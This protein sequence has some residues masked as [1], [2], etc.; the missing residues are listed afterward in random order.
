MRLVN[1]RLLPLVLPLGLIFAL[2]ACGV[3]GG[4]DSHPQRAAAPVQQGPAADYPVVLG[5]PYTIDGTLYSPVDTLNY[6][7]VGLAALDSEGG[8]AISAALRTLPVPSYVE[9]TSLETGRTILVRAERRGPMSGSRFVALSPGAM[10]QLG[11]SDGT[12]VRVRRVNPPEQERAM[13]RRGEQVPARMDTP[14]SLVNVLKRKLPAGTLVSAPLAATPTPTVPAAMPAVPKPLAAA[15]IPPSKHP[16]ATL[17]SAPTPPPAQAA[18]DAVAPAP[19]VPARGGFIVQAGAFARKENADRAAAELS[20]KVD[21]AG[22]LYR[23]RTGPFS[24]HKEAE[25]SLAKV[26]HAGY[27]GARIYSVE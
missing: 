5:E 25:A 15:A 19:A 22:T 24:T 6:D 18:P 17:P 14:Q 7:E 4:G 2:S 10:V 26:T 8:D 9:V 3:V 23:V 21:K 13:L 12:P 1:E 20:G 27:S 16:V 11:G